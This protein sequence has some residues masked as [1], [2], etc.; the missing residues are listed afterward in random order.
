MLNMKVNIFGV[1]RSGTK[2]VQLYTCLAF[3]EKFEYCGINYEPFYWQSRKC[4]GVSK[5]GTAEH[6]F[7]PLLIADS[8]LGNYR[9]GFLKD[10]ST[11]SEDIPLV[12]KFIRGNGRIGFISNQM[13]VDKNILV[14]RCLP[15]VLNSLSRDNWDFLGQRF[16]YK[17]DWPRFKEEVRRVS[18]RL[19]IEWLKRI[20]ENDK[21]DR[22]AVYWAVMNDFAIENNRGI[23]L[24]IDFSEIKR[25]PDG[26]LSKV[27]EYLSL[28][29]PEINFN[30]VPGK[31]IHTEK[32]IQ[33]RKARTYFLEM[34]KIFLEPFM[35]KNSK[36]L[37]IQRI[38][39]ILERIYCSVFK[40]S[41]KEEGLR[42]DIVIR[43]K[44]NKTPSCGH[45][46]SSSV[47]G[48]FKQNK[49]YEEINN[50]IYKKIDKFKE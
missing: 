16:E 5:Q 22:N 40:W 43:K 49:F 20:D 11:I 34:P 9:S 47:S 28:P 32:I 7:L 14:I 13:G 29:S 10:I 39:T 42:P 36:N 1:G 31:E 35:S 48:E 25:N 45:I 27:A 23:V 17:N 8:V 44:R 38:S 2:I 41:E 12:S 46:I 4:K 50:Y 30:C 37:L 24:M 6:M 19:Y 3:L 15:A 33:S 21:F 18:N 26:E